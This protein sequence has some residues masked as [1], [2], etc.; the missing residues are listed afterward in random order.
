MAAW[1]SHEAER[2]ASDGSFGSF[3]RRRRW[4]GGG[5]LRAP[6]PPERRRA[7]RAEPGSQAQGSL[8]ARWASV[9]DG[10]ATRGPGDS[11]R[12]RLFW[13]ERGAR[14]ALRGPR[15]PPPPASSPL[16]RLPPR[17]A[18]SLSRFLE[19]E[20]PASPPAVAPF[21]GRLVLAHGFLPRP[22]KPPAPSC[23]ARPGLALARAGRPRRSTRSA[24]PG[25][26][27]SRPLHAHPARL[28]RLRAES[29]AAHL[30]DLDPRTALDAPFPSRVQ[31]IA[32]AC[33]R[34]L[35]ILALIFL[36]CPGHRRR[37]QRRTH[38]S[39]GG[40]PAP[41]SSHPACAPR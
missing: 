2:A 10:Q 9:Q 5:V 35:P 41:Q 37:C 39:L 20:W 7:Q 19:A 11:G 23:T 33:S 36:C 21:P 38:R 30:Q 8:R 24:P 29:P 4:E 25:G 1:G 12:R 14:P 27:S 32:Q 18:F 3:E 28:L 22:P 34:H 6:L 15:G 26:R 17:G 13:E 16:C 31:P 40:P